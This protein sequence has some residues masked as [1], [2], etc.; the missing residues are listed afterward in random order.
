[1][2]R[3]RYDVYMNP[4]SDNPV[5]A[6]SAQIHIDEHSG[7]HEQIRALFEQ[8]MRMYSVSGEEHELANAVEDFLRGR[9]HLELHR[10]G[11]TVVASTHHGRDTRIVLAG[12]LDTVPVIHNFPPLWLEPG[13]TRIRPEIA[14]AHPDNRVMWGRGSADMKASDAVML[15]LATI[16]DDCKYDLTY[17]FY[18]HEEVAAEHN[19][20][21]KVVAAHP[22]WIQA[23]FAII[24]EPTSCAIEGGCNGTMR[25]DVVTHGVAAHSARA[26]MGK[27][28]IHEAADILNRLNVFEARKFSVDGLEYQEGLN[29][30]MISGGSGTNVIPEECRVHINY[31]FAPDKSMEQAKSLMFGE[32]SGIQLG[33]Q[34]TKAP[35][36]IFAG[37]GIVMHDESPSARP[38]MDAPMSVSL[39]ELVKKHTGQEPRAKMGWTDVARFSQIGIPA[40]NFGAG[41]PLLAHKHDEQVPIDDLYRMADIL[42]TWLS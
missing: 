15:Y 12:H 26:W 6:S 42:L 5:S 18:D 22:E 11:D 40:V 17:V 25:F 14:K 29:A 19:G 28:A 27:N 3:S 8:I 21:R 7:G 10:L 39:A 24:G 1:M 38:G 33:S 41:D 34:E 23:D 31:R 2:L 32:E 36:G 20:L 35:G 30:T 16:L 37:Y 9:E 4:S 13:D